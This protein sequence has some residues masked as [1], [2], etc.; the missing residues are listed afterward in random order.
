[1]SRASPQKK[2]PRSRRS[3]TGQRTPERIVSAL[4]NVIKGM[5]P[6]PTEGLWCA[7]HLATIR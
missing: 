6:R 1:M 7:G 2:E 3:K 5:M 4:C